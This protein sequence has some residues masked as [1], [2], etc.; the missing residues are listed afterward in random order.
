LGNLRVLDALAQAGGLLAGA[1]PEIIV[2]QAN[3]TAQRLS[4]RKLFDGLHPELNVRVGMGYQ[5]T[6]PEC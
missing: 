3:G 6:V 1:C 5:I 4:V 2:V